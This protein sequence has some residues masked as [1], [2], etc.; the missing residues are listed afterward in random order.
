MSIVR[1][2]CLCTF[3]QCQCVNVLNIGMSIV[4]PLGNEQPYFEIS[5]SAD[6]STPL[7]E[8]INSGLF[9][10]FVDLNKKFD[11]ENWR[12][13]IDAERLKDE[14]LLNLKNSIKLEVVKNQ[15]VFS[16]DHSSGSFIVS[17]VTENP[18]LIV[19]DSSFESKWTMWKN[20]GLKKQ[21]P[22]SKGYWEILDEYA[23]VPRV[24]VKHLDVIRRLIEMEQDLKRKNIEIK[25]KMNVVIY[26]SVDALGVKT[27]E[28]TGEYVLEYYV[29][30]EEECTVALAL[31]ITKAFHP[32]I[33]K[34]DKI[35]TK[36]S[37]FLYFKPE[38]P[39]KVEWNW[40][41]NDKAVYKEYDP[42]L[43]LNIPAQIEAT[44][45]GVQEYNF[46][47]QRFNRA[48]KAADD[49]Q[50]IDG[51]LTEF[52]AA[53]RQRFY[54]KGK[55]KPYVMRFT[56]GPNEEAQKSS[57]TP[58]E[59]IVKKV[60]NMEQV[61]VNPSGEKFPRNIRRL[62]MDEVARASAF[63]VRMHEIGKMEL[64]MDSNRTAFLRWTFPENK[65][66]DLQKEYYFECNKAN[67]E[68]MKTTLMLWR[69]N[70]LFDLYES[71]IRAL[72]NEALSKI[73][74]KKQS[75][76]F[77]SFEK[78]VN[79]PVSPSNIP[80]DYEGILKMS[81]A[82]NKQ[83]NELDG[84]LT[85]YQERIKGISDRT[86][87]LIS[88]QKVQSVISIM[89]KQIKTDADPFIIA[90]SNDKMLLQPTGQSG[91][92]SSCSWSCTNSKSHAALFD[93]SAPMKRIDSNGTIYDGEIAGFTKN[94]CSTN[95]LFNF[96]VN[97]S[98]HYTESLFIFKRPNSANIY[99]SHNGHIRKLSLENDDE[100]LYY[101]LPSFVALAIGDYIAVEPFFYPDSGTVVERL[102]REKTIY[103]KVRTP[104]NVYYTMTYHELTHRDAPDIYY[105]AVQP[106]LMN[107]GD[108]LKELQLGTKDFDPSNTSHPLHIMA[109]SLFE[110]SKQT[111]SAVEALA[112]KE[113]MA[114]QHKLQR[115]GI[116]YLLF[117][118]TV[119]APY[120]DD[121][122]KLLEEQT[123]SLKT[124]EAGKKPT[125]YI[126]PVTLENFEK[127]KSSG[128][129][130]QIDRMLSKLESVKLISSRR[131]ID[132][133]LSYFNLNQKH[134]RILNGEQKVYVI[135]I[136]ETR[137]LV[138][139]GEEV[140]EVK[141]E[142][143]DEVDSDSDHSDAD[144]QEWLTMVDDG[145]LAISGGGTKWIEIQS[146]IKCSIEYEFE[147][148]TNIDCGRN[149]GDLLEQ[150]TAEDDKQRGK[151]D[152]E[153]SRLITFLHENGIHNEFDLCDEDVMQQIET[154]F[155]TQ[156]HEPRARRLSEKLQK[157]LDEMNKDTDHL[158]RMDM[159]LSPANRLVSGVETTRKAIML[160]H[161]YLS[162]CADIADDDDGDDDGKEQGTE[163]NV[164]ALVTEV[165]DELKEK[166]KNL[167]EFRGQIVEYFVQNPSIDCDRIRGMMTKE[168]ATALVEHCDGNKKIKGSANALLKRL[169][170]KIDPSDTETVEDDNKEE[171]KGQEMQSMVITYN[172]LQSV[173][174]TKDSVRDVIHPVHL[175]TAAYSDKMDS[176]LHSFQLEDIY[177][178]WM[179][180]PEFP[181]T[182]SLL[183]QQ[184]QETE[185]VQN[186]V[187]TL[188]K[189]IRYNKK[190]DVVL[191]PSSVMLDP[192]FL[193][194]NCF[195]IAPKIEAI[196][197]NRVGFMYKGIF[198][199][200]KKKPSGLVINTDNLKKT[201]VA[202][203]VDDAKDDQKESDPPQKEEAAAQPPKD[204]VSLVTETLDELIAGTKPK[205]APFRDG[206]IDYFQNDPNGKE[207]ESPK[208][209]E[210]N[211]KDF[212]AALAAHCK[213]KK[214]KG[215]AGALYKNMVEK[216][217]P[218]EPEP[219]KTADTEETKVD[220]E[221]DEKTAAEA[222]EAE[223]AENRFF[224]D[225]VK[226]LVD[227]L[228]KNIIENARDWM[229]PRDSSGT[230]GLRSIIERNNKAIPL[231]WIKI[232]CGSC[233]IHDRGGGQSEIGPPPGGDY[234]D[235]FPKLL[236]EALFSYGIDCCIPFNVD[237]I[238]PNGTNRCDIS[239]KLMVEPTKIVDTKCGERHRF[240][241]KCI[242]QWTEMLDH[243]YLGTLKTDYMKSKFAFDDNKPD[244][245]PVKVRK[246]LCL[247]RNDLRDVA[248]Y[249]PCYCP[250][251]WKCAEINDDG[252][253][254]KLDGQRITMSDVE[255]T[256][257]NMEM[258]KK[259]PMTVREQLEEDNDVRYERLRLVN[260]YQQL[261][262]W[263]ESYK[264]SMDGAVQIREDYD[265]QALAER[266]PQ[267]AMEIAA[268]F[269]K[270]SNNID[271]NKDENRTLAEL[272]KQNPQIEMELAGIT[273]ST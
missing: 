237:N 260:D 259:M 213:E 7:D 29:R 249:L 221:N 218:K 28:K 113:M 136:A 150:Y 162:L 120:S 149:I 126:D 101:F 266:N 17:E 187:D 83:W 127:S 228:R 258:I 51:Q 254:T 169:K 10:N 36:E 141:A 33:D 63:D 3:T 19:N 257:E 133:E 31:T 182:V 244:G 233:F 95:K 96:M 269:N 69:T 41:D 109:L 230:D 193:E 4:D 145:N 128:S 2:C 200:R 97:V 186:M 273:N 93:R 73:T 132:E 144:D 140:V 130:K 192:E 60:V 92:T 84:A 246:D 210:M 245:A 265:F 11:A 190:Y 114:I 53:I 216:I 188:S 270:D 102:R 46:P 202:I 248:I 111:I 209:L 208:L 158:Q 9:T 103:Y 231:R 138:K 196:A 134:Q 199:V 75:A 87:T 168:F 18:T 119:N 8:P 106:S 105:E 189:L 167:G 211:K 178:D 243:P 180:K 122:K 121:V 232:G 263:L 62:D 89:K 1:V 59:K 223:E 229:D 215:L 107:A 135:H 164:I 65:G 166:K 225:E 154:Y 23:A 110:S 253:A 91:G 170:E 117:K 175:Y 104:K 236:R 204:M 25:S 148:S 26:E 47:L 160:Q 44:Y 123:E 57:E 156:N 203:P 174:V 206:I 74:S 82:D 268:A 5:G 52:A 58:P 207:I 165:I 67:S 198:Y 195:S 116:T 125:L 205:L 85:N 161:Q 139:M 212:C 24:P 171:A 88:L 6:P 12:M 262:E 38:G 242:L 49:R 181:K 240:D 191:V 86:F 152:M 238:D 271:W 43:G 79:P 76:D 179:K 99:I 16:V 71:G 219:P 48:P 224:L 143:E 34:K 252:F 20:R 98:V 90:F 226:F 42:T 15:W 159:M 220:D 68:L 172:P 54:P 176:F 272:I 147:M 247:E 177:N 30:N 185:P 153:D 261:Q 50:F 142:D 157:F 173:V 124:V 194:K 35:K 72:P 27:D 251:F 81:A 55:I 78:L 40:Y 80:R 255:D 146:E 184:S 61:A 94:V 222:K 131:E 39:G 256:K 183:Y 235:G 197:V 234:D 151:G 13:Q 77:D 118:T 217:K 66:L 112:A 21:Y 239:G 64:F 264:Q 137:K 241:R 115:S 70:Y 22:T 37:C 45:Q 32:D 155:S 163:P 267:H 201:Q 100:D 214:V 14:L 250:K 227:V 129:K 56:F 108:P